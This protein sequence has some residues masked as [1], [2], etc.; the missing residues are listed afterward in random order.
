MGRRVIGHTMFVD[1]QHIFEILI[2]EIV[3]CQ[4]SGQYFVWFETVPGAEINL[5]V[6][7]RHLRNPLEDRCKPWAEAVV[8]NHAGEPFDQHGIVIKILTGTKLKRHLQFRKTLHYAVHN[9]LC[10]RI[11][12]VGR[13]IQDHDF[14]I[15]LPAVPAF[16]VTAGFEIHLFR[17]PLNL[18]AQL[19]RNQGGV[20]Q[21]QGNRLRGNSQ[22]SG[23]IRHACGGFFRFIHMVFASRFILSCIII[24]NLK[25]KSIVVL[26]IN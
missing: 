24:A 15:V 3:C 10:H 14:F 5:F 6:H 17:D 2:Y 23:D 9:L 19:L 22:H 26:K 20:A 4:F 21:G 16:P 1:Q 8:V 18:F 7:D 11:A 25:Q 12:H 13:L